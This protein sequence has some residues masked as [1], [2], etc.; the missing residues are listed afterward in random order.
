MDNKSI[1]EK[2]LLEETNKDV[3]DIDNQDFIS[4][5]TAAKTFIHQVQMLSN[6]HNLQISKKNIKGK[7]EAL[8]DLMRKDTQYTRDIL[9]YQHTFENALDTFLG[10]TIYLSYVMP[11]GNLRF[12][13]EAKI[14]ELYKTAAKQWGRGNITKGKVLKLEEDELQKEIQDEIKNSIRNK[15]LVY[16]EALARY[17][18]KN[19]EETYMHYNPSERTFY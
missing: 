17:T 4:L 8:Y 7:I 1:I 18:Q 14:G 5:Q 10:R 16:Q 11:D 15:N 19:K 3:L 6:Q 9:Q 12:Y 13:G 2:S